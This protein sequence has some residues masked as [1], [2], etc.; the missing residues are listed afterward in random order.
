MRNGN[1]SLIPSMKANTLASLVYLFTAVFGILNGFWGFL[2]LVTFVCAVVLI[3]IE[4]NSFVRRACVQVIFLHIVTFV[5]SLIFGILLGKLGFFRTVHWIICTIVA[6]LLC[7]DPTALQWATDRIFRLSE[8]LLILFVPPW[9]YN[10]P[11]A[12]FTGRRRSPRRYVFVRQPRKT[13]YFP[14]KRI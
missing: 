4:K 6:L 3:F 12:L 8:T 10:L 9:A 2:A 14:H 7:T 13:M 5:S 11:R 1:S